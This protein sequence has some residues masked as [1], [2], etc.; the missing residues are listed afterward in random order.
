VT[1]FDG[2]VPRNIG[3]L[4]TTLGERGDPTGVYFAEVRVK[5][6]PPPAVRVAP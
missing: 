1:L 4:A 3:V 2:I 6:P 5:L